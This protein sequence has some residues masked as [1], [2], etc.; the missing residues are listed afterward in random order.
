MPDPVDIYVTILDAR[1]ALVN[2]PHRNKPN[3]SS[4]S[5]S[6]APPP[7]QAPPPHFTHRTEMIP[8]NTLWRM[9]TAHMQRI[10]AH[11]TCTRARL[12]VLR[13]WLPLPPPPMPNCARSNAV[14]GAVRTVCWGPCGV[15]S[16]SVDHTTTYMY[17]YRCMSACGDRSMD[18]RV[19]RRRHAM[20]RVECQYIMLHHS[21]K[22]VIT[23][24]VFRLASNG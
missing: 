2:A 19:Q 6:R 12:T 15:C 4:S 7:R 10:T 20:L 21:H 24:N 22:C 3:T 23:L 1:H 13:D 11:C 5:S 9:L 18:Q 14:D 8:H 16:V 17:P